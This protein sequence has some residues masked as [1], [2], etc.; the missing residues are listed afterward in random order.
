MNEP[1]DAGKPGQDSEKTYRCFPLDTATRT[2]TSPSRDRLRQSDRSKMVVPKEPPNTPPDRLETPGTRAVPPPHHTARLSH[3]GSA[4]TAGSA[5]KSSAANRRTTKPLDALSC[6]GICCAPRA[7]APSGCQIRRR[8]QDSSRRHSI[9]R[10]FGKNDVQGLPGKEYPP[11]APSK[12]VRY[13]HSEAAPSC[14]PIEMVGRTSISP[15]GDCDIPHVLEVPEDLHWG[16]E[17]VDLLDTPNRVRNASTEGKKHRTND[18]GHDASESGPAAMVFGGATSRRGE[19]PGICDRLALRKQLLKRSGLPM[20]DPVSLVVDKTV[21]MYPET[22]TAPPRTDGV[23]DPVDP[24]IV[25]KIDLRSLNPP[26]SCPLGVAKR[27]LHDPGA[28]EEFMLEKKPPLI[29]VPSSRQH[30]RFISELLEVGIANKDRYHVRGFAKFFTVLKKVNEEGIAILRTIL[31]CRTANDSF[32]QPDPVNLPNVQEILQEFRSVPAIRALD[33]RHMYHQVLIG[34]HLRPFFCVAIGSL[35]VLWK[36]LAM[37]WKWAC[38]VAQA[39]STFAVAGEA[40]YQWTELPRSVKLGACTFFVVYDN[41]LGGGPAE[42]LTHIWSIIKERLEVTLHATI[43]EDLYAVSGSSLDVLGLSWTPSE[44]GL[45]WCLLPKFVEKLNVAEPIK[46]TS[47]SSLKSL[48]KL[49]GLVA[50]GRYATRG[51]LFDMVPSYRRLADAVIAQGWR[52]FDNPRCYAPIF[53]AIA[54]LRSAGMQSFNKI[55]DEVIVFSDAHI[56]GYGFVG[57]EPLVSHSGIWSKRFEAKDMFFLE[58]IAAKLASCAFAKA[59]RCI[60]LIADNQALVH[61]IRKRSTSCPRTAAVLLELFNVLRLCNA[62]IVSHWIGTEYNPADELSRQRALLTEKL[63][64]ALSHI[65]WTAPQ[66]PQWG[67]QLGRAV[68]LSRRGGGCRDSLL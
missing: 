4:L 61:A 22:A 60:N 36:V 5:P 67:S 27:L 47:S 20:Y 55:H 53:A 38:F 17:G 44:S 13:D 21:V 24:F 63:S 18:S 68:G 65:A 42:E 57:G 9:H 66:A 43:K 11:A 3:H 32:R 48:A 31:D 34:E 64:D 26:P 62:S 10:S 58:A 25:G 59:G 23:L 28:L 14:P 29:F 30:Q 35:R 12:V 56:T 52:G 33:L 49:L 16:R 46:E 8:V 45:S 6:A 40:A 7:D 50:W 1:R 15:V 2:G 51:D 37:G 41:I 19:H 54:A 39:I